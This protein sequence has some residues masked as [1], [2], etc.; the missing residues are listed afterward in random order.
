MTHLHIL[1]C[2]IFPSGATMKFKLWHNTHNSRKHSEDGCY[3]RLDVQRNV[4]T[5]PQIHQQSTDSTPHTTGL[6]HYV[7]H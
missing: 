5:T 3:S 2:Q 1:K 6:C 4:I 7:C